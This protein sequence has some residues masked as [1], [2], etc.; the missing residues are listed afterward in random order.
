MRID[1]V[2]ILAGNKGAAKSV[3]C[4]WYFPCRDILHV[5]TFKMSRL[6]PIAIQ[7]TLIILG[8]FNRNFELNNLSFR[9]R[10]ML[11]L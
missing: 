11:H 10:F 7:E 2:S 5:L 9:R 3:K 6:R 1:L 4:D 8:D